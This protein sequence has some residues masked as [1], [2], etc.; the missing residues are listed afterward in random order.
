MEIRKIFSGSTPVRVLVLD[1]DGTLSTLRSGWEQVMRDMMVE[2]LGENDAENITQYIE[3]SAGIQTIHQMKWLKDRV[4]EKT[5]KSLDAWDYKDEYNRR[6]MLDVD[7]KKAQL[8]AGQAERES[9]LM[10][11]AVPF[12]KALRQLGVHLHVASGTDQED[13]IKEAELLGVSALVDSISGAPYRAENCSKEKVLGD[14]IARKGL[15]GPQV[16]V[17]GDGRVEIALGVQM[18]ARTLGLASDEIKR[19]GINPVKRGRLVEADAEAIVGDF[20]AWE[21]LL[22]WMNLKGQPS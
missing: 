9:F 7:R 6:L 14:L 21:T 1:F 12:L 13:V 2:Y 8:A 17:I 15:H 11:G 10:A 18:G 22:G 4:Q 5:G 19:E 3:R 20:L 16:C